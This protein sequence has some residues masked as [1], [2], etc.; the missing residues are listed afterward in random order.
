MEPP[1]RPAATAPP[2]T[3]AAVRA[4]DPGAFGDLFTAYADPDAKGHP[5]KAALPTD[6]A[7]L[8]KALRARVKIPAD[9]QLDYVSIGEPFASPAMLGAQGKKR[10]VECVTVRLASGNVDKAGDR[11]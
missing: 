9:V 8:L 7:E 3:R 1:T 6:P 5:A 10:D 2:A 11:P 4:G